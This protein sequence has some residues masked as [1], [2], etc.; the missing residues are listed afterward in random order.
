MN[1]WLI[2]P[3]VQIV[4]INGNPVVG[5][6]VFV[7]DADTSNLSTIYSDETTPIANPVEIDELGNV[8]IWAELSKFY[9]IAVYDTGDNL[10][11]AKKHICPGI[12][13]ET[14][15]DI[16][17]GDGCI[18]TKSGDTYTISVD[19]D[20]VA[21][22]AELVNKQDK[23]EAGRNIEIT[24]ANVI[25]VTGRRAIVTQAPLQSNM[26]D[27]AW[28]VSF[29]SDAFIGANGLMETTKLEYDSTSSRYVSYNGVPLGEAASTGSLDGYVP[30]SATALGIGIDN[31]VTGGWSLGLG[32]GN[33]A[34]SSIALG[35]RNEVTGYGVGI[36]QINT[37]YGSVAIGRYNNAAIRSV[38]LGL[39]ASANTDSFAILQQASAY[40]NSI[41][42]GYSARA[43]K[44][45]IAEGGKAS[46]Y[47]YSIALGENSTAA[48]YSIA[49]NGHA[50]AS[51]CIALDG[52]A[53][54]PMCIAVGFKSRA[55]NS[56]IAVGTNLRAGS[57]TMVFGSYNYAPN[58][59]NGGWIFANGKWGTTADIWDE[60]W[61][62]PYGGISARW[63]MSGLDYVFATGGN[64]GIN[65]SNSA[66]LRSLYSTVKTYSSTWGGGSL[67]PIVNDTY[68]ADCVG[69]AFKILTTT[70]TLT[71]SENGATYASYPSTNMDATWTQ[72][73]AKAN[74]P[75][76]VPTV[77]SYA[78][79]VNG[80]VDVQYSAVDNV[81][82]ITFIAASWGNY[83]N[84][85]ANFKD[86]D[87]NKGTLVIPSGK[88]MTA[89]KNW[90][91]EDNSFRWNKKLQ[92]GTLMSM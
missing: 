50:V 63:S 86:G 74:E 65:S 41:A 5:G 22:Q 69:S 71:L 59:A 6:K 46:A 20:T 43:E 35:L 14:N 75:Q 76:Y 87:T 45:S 2:S 47:Y 62:T 27:S 13:S 25:N 16:N 67:F 7:Y 10:L 73:I 54:N 55:E 21:T 84:Y 44:D 30:F 17:A 61:I 40:D 15:L 39:N 33:T 23:L 4:D 11:F 1:N 8:T 83:L 89:T 56:G 52:Y 80:E 82:E 88:C 26:S 42:M 79:V 49:I 36:G 81:N 32:S 70:S 77:S 60:A 92:D 68:T 72:I 48:N 53:M 78:F 90:N 24:P 64:T 28:I 3:T 18:V 58:S 85:S 19:F 91:W 31:G 12:L 9:D 34:N 51:H 29:D 66:N 37:A 57:G 38:A